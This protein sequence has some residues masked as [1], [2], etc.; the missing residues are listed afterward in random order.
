M[1]TSQVDPLPDILDLTGGNG[2][3][4]FSFRGA[5]WE[6]AENT[7]VPTG[8]GVFNPFLRVQANGLEQGYNTDRPESGLG[9]VQFDEK[10]G[11]WTRSLKFS[12][13]AINSDG[14]F[15]FALDLDEPNGGT[16]DLLS[17]Q[18]FQLFTTSDKN[19]FG[20]TYDPTTLFGSNATLRYDMDRVGGSKGGIADN[21]RVDLDF[22]VA[23]SGSGRQDLFVFINKSTFFSGVAP[24]DYVV[25]YPMLGSDSNISVL[26]L[27]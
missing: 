7:N 11:I 2:G 13:L 27:R 8:T 12:E 14:N 3:S 6:T 20:A 1:L 9:S 5:S 19:I 16:T 21:A 25:L 17:L 26:Q 18:K 10:T 15:Q 24:D 23:G 22:D 4:P